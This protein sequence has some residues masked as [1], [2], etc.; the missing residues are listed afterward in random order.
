MDFLKIM[1]IPK[2]PSSNVWFY[3]NNLAA[4][5]IRQYQE[6]QEILYFLS[7]AVRRG[8]GGGLQYRKWPLGQTGNRAERCRFFQFDHVCSVQNLV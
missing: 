3:L 2:L 7:W 5:I 4:V 8:G 6:K 1:L